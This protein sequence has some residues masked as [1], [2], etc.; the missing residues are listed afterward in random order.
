MN[1]KEQK[2]EPTTDTSDTYLSRTK[3]CTVL[4]VA[5]LAGVAV[6]AFF[7]A[8]PASESV[9]SHP[10]VAIQPVAPPAVEPEKTPYRPPTF[11]ESFAR[12]TKMRD[13]F[14]EIPGEDQ[15]VRMKRFQ[16]YVLESAKQYQ[17]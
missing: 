5:L 6:K 3:V 14:K 2:L 17:H 10:I 11:K 12:A 9:N 16:E 7:N 13:G 8:S 4:L 15:M 1:N